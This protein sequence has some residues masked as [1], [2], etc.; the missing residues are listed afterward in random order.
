MTGRRSGMC[1][2]I[3]KICTELLVLG[4]IPHSRIA[5]GGAAW[6]SSQR[7]SIVYG[8]LVELMHGIS[9]IC[10]E[11]SSPRPDNLKHDRHGT[12]RLWLSREHSKLTK[13]VLSSRPKSAD[14]E[15]VSLRENPWAACT[16]SRLG[17]KYLCSSV[18]ILGIKKENGDCLFFF[19]WEVPQ[20][21]QKS[22]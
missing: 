3:S 21:A 2:R 9:K 17:S 20:F 11:P 19:P 1:S 5:A 14:L 12:G 22:V 15:W 16:A 4:L 10:T 18:F 8:G 7:C 6:S 13:F